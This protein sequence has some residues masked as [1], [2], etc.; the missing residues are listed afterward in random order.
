MTPGKQSILRLLRFFFRILLRLR[1]H[2]AVLPTFSGLV[3]VAPHPDD[4]SFGC[5]AWI[6]HCRTNHLP[7]HVFVF[8]DGDASHPGHPRLTPESLV[9]LRRQECLEACAELGVPAT[10]VEFLGLADGKLDRPDPAA[11]ARVMALLRNRAEKIPDELWMLPGRHE[12]SSEHQGAR[13]LALDAI[14]Q[15][16]RPP[17][18]WD[19]WIWAWRNPLALS[20][21]FFSGKLLVHF[22][23]RNGPKTRAIARHQ[24]QVEPVPPWTVPVMERDLAATL[25]CGE[26]FFWIES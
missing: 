9:A 5:G 19:Y 17:A 22:Y 1:S 23:P 21:A 18:I 12:A 2:R 16:V 6:H 11:R 10:E 20:P 7:V 3:V 8:S 25:D 26:E 13:N 15:A 24:S 4:E 14:S